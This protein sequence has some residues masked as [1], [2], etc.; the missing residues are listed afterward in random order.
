[1]YP[2]GHD[3][4]ER[5][6]C[7]QKKPTGT[8]CAMSSFRFVLHALLLLS[9]AHAQTGGDEVSPST[10]ISEPD[11]ST[12]PSQGKGIDPHTDAP[13]DEPEE[14]AEAGEAAASEEDATRRASEAAASEELAE[15]QLEE[16][17]DNEI[18]DATSMLEAVDVEGASPQTCARWSARPILFM[19]R[20]R[21]RE[22]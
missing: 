7:R 18:T 16:M 6:S 2:V 10:E 8:F 3:F 5:L 19:V 1:M 20:S 22:R 13:A 12:Y 11:D 4:L 15:T 17:T 14:D 9:V 21:W